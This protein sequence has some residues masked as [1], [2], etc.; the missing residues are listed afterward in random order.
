MKG[1]SAGETYHPS[2]TYHGCRYVEVTGL[3]SLSMDDIE[4][5]HFHSESGNSLPPPSARDRL[6]Q[7]VAANSGERAE[8]EDVLLQPH[9][10]GDP[11]DGSRSAEVE[12]D[13]GTDGLRPA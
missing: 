5:H 7:A 6:T 12:H 11:A 4:Y 9:R 2:F 10:G 13:D 3:E 1:D 8:G